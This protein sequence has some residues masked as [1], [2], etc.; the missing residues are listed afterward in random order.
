MAKPKYNY[1][2]LESHPKVAGFMLGWTAQ[3]I[4]SLTHTA[5]CSADDDRWREAGREFYR[6]V[7]VCKAMT[8]PAKASPQELDTCVRRLLE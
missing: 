6:I 8:D 5:V 3:K 2:K 7:A 4:V 1:G